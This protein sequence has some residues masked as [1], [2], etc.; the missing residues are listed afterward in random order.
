MTADTYAVFDE[1]REKWRGKVALQGVANL[2]LPL[3][4]NAAIADKHVA[5][6]LEHDGV[7]LGAY[8]GMNMKDTDANTW[9]D[10]LFTYARKVRKCTL[11]RIGLNSEANQH[12]E[13][14][15]HRA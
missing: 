13:L 7:V 10:A 3:W 2:F 14:N 15:S 12:L 1:A 8:C 6:A 4:A 9:F 11:D 5:E